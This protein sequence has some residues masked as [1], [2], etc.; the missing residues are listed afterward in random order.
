MLNAVE[1]LS[2][3][4]EP[5]G[6][7][8][9]ASFAHLS[10][11]TTFLKTV[12]ILT[13]TV[14]TVPAFAQQPKRSVASRLQRE[15]RLSHAHELLGKYYSKSA[16]KSGEKVDK[17]NSQIYRWVR[18]HLNEEQRGQ[19]KVVA[20]AIIDESLKYNMDP[21]FLLSVIQ[22]ESSFDV[23]RL[24]TLDEIGLMQLRP[25]TAEWIAQKHGLKYTGA[26]SLFNPVTNIR[27]GA[28]FLS[29]LR[30]KFDSHAQ[31]YLAAYNMGARNVN[32]AREKNIWPKDYPQHVM[33][34]YVEFYGQLD[35]ETSSTKS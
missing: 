6:S 4:R 35:E 30:E 3:I 10:G 34:F 22:G 23:Q 19:Y 27:I 14:L 21:V 12:S 8:P 28:A 13:A 5:S 15:A 11:M 25:S 17:I 7:P 20:Q 16:V 29:Y 24:G 26:Q 33:K 18:E 32:E 2:S 1:G 9:A 31:L